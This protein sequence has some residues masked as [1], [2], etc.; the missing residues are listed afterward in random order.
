MKTSVT[1]SAN[2]ELFIQS[3]DHLTIVL[4]L[5]DPEPTGVHDFYV[6]YHAVQILNC[7][8]KTGL[9]KIQVKIANL[10]DAS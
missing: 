10:W 8:L 1:S 7:C 3:L 6:Y 5:L 4:S 9:Y 2:C